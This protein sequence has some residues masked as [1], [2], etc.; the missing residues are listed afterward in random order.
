MASTEPGAN[1]IITSAM[2]NGVT[3]IIASAAAP[4]ITIDTPSEPNEATDEAH[5]HAERGVGE[6]R[7]GDGAKRNHRRVDDPPRHHGLDQAGAVQH[8]R[9]KHRAEQEAAGE[10]DVEQQDGQRGRDGD[11]NC[12]LRQRLERKLATERLEDR[13]HQ[14]EAGEPGRQAD[15]YD[16]HPDGCTTAM[17]RMSAPSSAATAITCDS[18]PGAAP[19][20]ADTRSQPCTFWR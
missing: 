17:P 8:G 6:P 2:R 1:A 20:N 4:P 3:A 19:R 13:P 14:A 7:A 18:P 10:I 16:H 12:Q 11:E 5:Q 9:R 15:R